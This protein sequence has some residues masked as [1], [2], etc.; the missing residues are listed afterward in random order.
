MNDIFRKNQR[1]SIGM[2]ASMMF[3]TGIRPLEY[4]EK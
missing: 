3:I 1:L 2:I 4:F